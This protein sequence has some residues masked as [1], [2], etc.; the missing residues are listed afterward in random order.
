MSC[1]ARMDG[2]TPLSVAVLLRKIEAGWSPRY[3]CFWGHEPRTGKAAGPWLLSQW[4]PCEFWVDGVIYPSAEHY[5]MAEKARLFGDAD[6]LSRILAAPSPAAAKALGRK[7][8]N[9]VRGVWDVHGFEIVTRGSAAKF[10]Q[11]GALLAYLLATSDKVLVE[12]SPVDRIW[13][14]GVAADDP[15]A[16]MPTEWLGTNLLGF[17]LMKARD[18]LRRAEG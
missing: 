17:A 6:A 1:D 7:V 15:R 16:E 5:M 3:L 10:G 11:N 14:A 8:K 18:L 2:E 9:F 12:A 4:W 13:G